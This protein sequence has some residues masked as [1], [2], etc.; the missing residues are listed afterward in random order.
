MLSLLTASM[1]P[2]LI[3]CKHLLVIVYLMLGEGRAVPA[4]Y[5]L[6]A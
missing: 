5:S 4:A 2:G 3:S 1:L 6:I